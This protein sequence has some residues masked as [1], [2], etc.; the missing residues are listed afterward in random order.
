MTPIFL[1]PRRSVYGA[2]PSCR[3]LKFGQQG[4]G[5]RPAIDLIRVSVQPNFAA[6]QIQCSFVPMELFTWSMIRLPTLCGFGGKI[7]LMTDQSRLD[8]CLSIVGSPVASGFGIGGRLGVPMSA[9][10]KRFRNGTLG[11]GAYDLNERTA[12]QP[13]LPPEE[14]V[15]PN[16]GA[17]H[18]YHRE[19]IAPAPLELRH[20][21]EIH[22]VD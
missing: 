14:Q 21:V 22:A 1:A 17:D 6:A 3:S 8:P 7:P 12:L 15:R 16:R 4:A 9:A 13:L 2:H 10:R 5:I 11:S 19:R 20:H 18:H